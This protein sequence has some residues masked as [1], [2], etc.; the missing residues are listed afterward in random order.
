MSSPTPRPLTDDERAQGRR[1]LENWR[2]IDGVLEQERSDRLAALTDDAAWNE[3]QG[4]LRAWEADMP[5]DGGE[6]LLLQ[7]RL[8]SKWPRKWP[9]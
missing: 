5:G 6:G 8:L 1:W 3:S 9:A 7:Q 2:E 4:L